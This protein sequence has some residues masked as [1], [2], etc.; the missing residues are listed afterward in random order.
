MDLTSFT[1]QPTVP[2][3]AALTE[4]I[5]EAMSALGILLIVFMII[6][7]LILIGTVA[8]ITWVVKRVWYAGRK[9]ERRQEQDWLTQA[10]TRQQSKYTYTDPYRPQ[11]ATKKPKGMPKATYDHT[12]G[13]WSPTGWYFNP[14]T[15][16]WEP[17]D[18]LSKASRERWKWNEEKRIWEDKTKK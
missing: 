4:P 15:G 2:I 7:L 5:S 17:P 3:D 12:G 18:Y 8:L 10:Q 14:K 1:T 16:L 9:P 13:Q 6:G 11:G